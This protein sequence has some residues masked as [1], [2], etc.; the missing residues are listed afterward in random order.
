MSGKAMILRILVVRDLN[1]DASLFRAER[2][3]H[4]NDFGAGV[5]L[6]AGGNSNCG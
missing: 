2:N 5:V 3:N 4:C 1:P 6:V